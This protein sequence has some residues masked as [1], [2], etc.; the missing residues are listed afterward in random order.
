MRSI[1]SICAAALCGAISCATFAQSEPDEIDQYLAGYMKDVVVVRQVTSVNGELISCVDVDHQ[2]GMNHPAFTGRIRPELSPEGKAIFEQSFGRIVP[3]PP[4]QYC[5]T[6]SVEM[7]LPTR[8]QIVHAGGL[9]AFHSKSPDGG[10][11]PPAGRP[12][13][14]AQH[15]PAQTR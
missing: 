9:R 12:L 5:P 1:M 11:A 15:D 14:D 7:I 3:A 2:P 13:P 6:G 4:S 10:S 8:A